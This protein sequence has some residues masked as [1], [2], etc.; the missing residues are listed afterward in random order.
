MQYI[1]IQIITNL[2]WIIITTKLAIT[3]TTAT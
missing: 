1:I 3:L 2:L